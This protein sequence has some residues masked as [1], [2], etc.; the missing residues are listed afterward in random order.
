VN[1]PCQFY[2]YRYFVAAA[3]ACRAAWD[4]CSPPS[5]R[6]QRTLVGAA[7]QIHVVGRAAGTPPLVDQTQKNR[8]LCAYLGAVRLDSPEG[9]SVASMGYRLQPSGAAAGVPACQGCDVLSVPLATALGGASVSGPNRARGTPPLRCT[10][11]TPPPRRK[12]G[13]SHAVFHVKPVQSALDDA[14]TQ[15]SLYPCEP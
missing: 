4:N 11:R 5:V 1:Q 7:A 10:A 14:R 12:A 8:L 13:I 9:L 6:G 2:L 3:S 15:D